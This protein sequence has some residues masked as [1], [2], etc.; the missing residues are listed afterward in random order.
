MSYC[1]FLFTLLNFLVYL[2]TLFLWYEDCAA[3]MNLVSVY[4]VQVMLAHGAD[5]SISSTNGITPVQFYFSI[6]FYIENGL[7]QLDHWLNKGC[8]KQVSCYFSSSLCQICGIFIS[9]KSYQ[10]DIVNPMSV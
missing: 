5:P 9:L 10:I 1:H 7:T 6:Y 3:I 4:S 2:V 8:A